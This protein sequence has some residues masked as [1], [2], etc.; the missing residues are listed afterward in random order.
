LLVAVAGVVFFT[1]LGRPQLWD[2]DEPRNAACAREML[3][4]GDWIVPTFNGELRTAKP[5]LLYWLIMS[6]Y[7]TLGVSEFSAR[8]WSALAGTG[9]VVLT[10]WLGR[11]LF[12][13][14]VGL[15]GALTLAP[16]VM[17]GV[18]ARAAT[19]DAVFVCCFTLAMFL[20]VKTASQPDAEISPADDP[21]QDWLP[22]RTRDA[23]PMYAAMGLA[24][25]AKGPVGAV[26][27]I[28][29]LVAF[30][31][32][33][34]WCALPLATEVGGAGL[35]HRLHQ[36][37]G[38][39]RRVM[40]PRELLRLIGRLHIPTGLLVI[41]AIALPW[42]AGVA[43]RTD[44]AWLARFLAY[45]NVGRFLQPL[46][47]HRGPIVYYVPA[48][49][50]GFYP[51]SVFLPLALVSLLLRWRRG[52]VPT[53]GD[54]FLASWAGL[55]VGFF[56]C[57][58]TKL[59]SYVLPAYPALALLTARWLVRGFDAAP[60]VSRAW[61]RVGIVCVAVGGIAMLLA[62]VALGDLLTVTGVGLSGVIPL[63]G[64]AVA[65]VLFE[66]RGLR[67]A[68]IALSVSAILTTTAIF[69]YE[70]ARV[71]QQQTSAAL[72]RTIRERAPDADI[73]ILGYY[74]P[75]LTFYARQSI[76]KL[77]TADDARELLANSPTAFVIANEKKYAELCE[78]LP[79]GVEVI[80]QLPE[81]L[82][83]RQ[84][85]VLGRT[86]PE[87]TAQSGPMPRR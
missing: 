66:R 58:G 87:S 28:G 55:Y 59:P 52:E 57:A 21:W 15:W 40:V 62:P 46:E 41:A 42:Y 39:L 60:S 65:I 47:N 24:V 63:V 3:D 14:R 82:K 18:S 29:I 50:A 76:R 77:R 9:T 79:P 43:L 34:R 78:N 13:T 25:L 16:A 74:R 31:L 70:A 73:A 72:I 53:G 48:I 64:S 10:Y 67:P 68:A 26:L 1:N 5:A 6:A 7:A 51:W 22:V 12:E 71:D 23:L 8:V 17:F 45:D 81:F 27:P 37:A 83:R 4:R 86:L 80:A 54:V 69:A 20:F 56:S 19:P 75:S 32:A 49:L 61:M 44:G 11:R 84:I 30:A 2:E 35:G 85:Y 36:F 33:L 38:K